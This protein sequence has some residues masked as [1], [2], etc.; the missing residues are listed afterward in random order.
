MDL[1]G[2]E[3]R[4]V[5]GNGCLQASL[6]SRVS[7]ATQWPTGVGF[8]AGPGPPPYRTMMVRVD[9]GNE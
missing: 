5:P 6:S 4:E 1:A 2:G 7:L 8:V 3:S 9:V